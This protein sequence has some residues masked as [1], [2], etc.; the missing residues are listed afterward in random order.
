MSWCHKVNPAALCVWVCDF[1]GSGLAPLTY[2][3]KFSQQDGQ[4]H[5]HALSV[6]LSLS[7][8]LSLPHT[9]MLWMKEG[10][11]VCP[12]VWV[13][14][15]M[16]QASCG[17]FGQHSRKVTGNITERKRIHTPQII[18]VGFDSAMGFFRPPCRRTPHPVS[19]SLFSFLFLYFTFFKYP[20]SWDV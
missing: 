8:S 11:S 2:F 19:I 9:H 12:T 6:M 13:Q 18:P 10:L 1:L 15:D 14:V 20:L 4:T 7:L 16:G 5:V 3:P 17:K